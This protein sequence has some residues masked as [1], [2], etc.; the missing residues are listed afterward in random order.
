MRGIKKIL[1]TVFSC[2]FLL[3]AY[4]KEEIVCNQYHFNYYLVNPAVAGAE[5]C[6][7]LM[8]TGRFQWMGQ[9]DHPMT[10]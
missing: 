4:A 3:H 1:T 8:L 5:R 2:A 7:H 9:E 6:T 10:Q